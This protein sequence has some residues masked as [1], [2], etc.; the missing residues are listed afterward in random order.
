MA[1]FD[2]KIARLEEEIEGYNADYK[3]ALAEDKRLLLQTINSARETLN[4]LLD[5]KQAL[6]E[7]R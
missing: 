3:T 2:K 1:E 7:G 4:R 6:S 5:E